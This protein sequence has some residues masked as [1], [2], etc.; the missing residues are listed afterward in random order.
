[1]NGDGITEGIMLVAAEFVDECAEHAEIHTVTLT[2]NGQ[3]GGVD[4]VV[5]GTVD[6]VR[7]GAWQDVEYTRVV[8]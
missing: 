2:A 8:H 3:H 4:V 1:M 5:K 7:E 6:D